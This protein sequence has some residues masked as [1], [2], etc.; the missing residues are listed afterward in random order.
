[1]RP[2][3]GG[4]QSSARKRWGSGHMLHQ[5][6]LEDKVVN[7]SAP[8]SHV[9]A[10]RYRSRGATSGRGSFIKRHGSPRLGVVEA[11]STTT[12]DGESTPG[13][14]GVQS[15]LTRSKSGGSDDSEWWKRLMVSRSGHRGQRLWLRHGRRIIVRSSS[16]RW[17]S[18][19]GGRTR[20]RWVCSR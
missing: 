12:A 16:K 10:R 1:M 6:L 4:D 9:E 20:H 14:I 2:R 15:R 13:Q 5:A 17:C 8:A 19:L 18:I 3:C 7:G 11:R